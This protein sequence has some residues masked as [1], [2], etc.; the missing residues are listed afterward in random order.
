MEGLRHEQFAAEYAPA[1][2]RVPEGSEREE[3]EG[4]IATDHDGGSVIPSE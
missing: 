1:M 3:E 2:C 4:K